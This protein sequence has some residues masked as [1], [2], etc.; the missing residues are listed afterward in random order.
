MMARRVLAVVAGIV[1]LLAC[2]W[3]LV[4]GWGAAG[5]G[6][7]AMAQLRPWIV[8]S[9]VVGV[10][11][12]WPRAQRVAL[13]ASVALALAS[14]AFVVTARQN[15]SSEFDDALNVAAVLAAL[16]ATLSVVAL[17]MRPSETRPA[18]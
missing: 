9:A 10:L 1:W 4:V 16:A 18:R 11:L 2:G 15:S 12:F 14:A 6:I 5:V 3:W 8:G 7:D 13:V 17:A